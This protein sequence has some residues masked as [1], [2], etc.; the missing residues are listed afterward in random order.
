[1]TF[2]QYWSILRKRWKFILVCFVLMGIGTYIG[3]KFVKPSYQSTVLVQVNVSSSTSDINN[4]LASDQLVQT[5][6]IVATS[7]P[8]LRE[9]ASHYKGITVDKLMKEVTVTARMNTQIFEIDV[10]DANP[11]LAAAIANDIAATLIKQQEQEIPQETAQGGFLVV[12]QSAV[13]SQNPIQSN[14]MLIIAAGLLA[15]LFL[16][17][18]LAILFEQIDPKIRTPEDL[19]KLLSWPILTTIWHSKSEALISSSNQ[20]P[21]AESYRMLRTNIGLSVIN[22]PLRSLLITSATPH[23]GKSVI[24]A[25]LA[26]FMAN[27]GKRTLLVDANLHSPAQHT[28]F[29]LPPTEAGLSDAIF[30][31]NMQTTKNLFS[32]QKFPSLLSPIRQSNMPIPPSFSLGPFMH[33]VGIPNL[34]IIPTGSPFP[35][36]SELFASQAMP[37]LM[38]SIENCGADVVIIDAPPLL[39]L[40][41]TS[42]LAAMVGATLFVVDITHAYKKTLKQAKAL[43]TQTGAQVLG[44]VVNKQI[45]RRGATPYTYYLHTPYNSHNNNHIKGKSDE[46]NQEMQNGHTLIVPSS[47]FISA[48]LNEQKAWPN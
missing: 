26:I 34:Q 36:A 21:N 23:E 18:L 15:G 35:D 10:V 14:K 17:M 20:N 7:D 22:Q 47:P 13:P 24:A 5:E 44:C 37:F 29:G 6:A 33:S 30:A 45:R 12:V 31:V 8:V 16:G 42:I 11:R 27:T 28:Q 9:V 48:S 40:S 43:I 25:N 41:D 4:L 32:G 1:M 2:E 19:A 39:G 46:M 38:S 3:N